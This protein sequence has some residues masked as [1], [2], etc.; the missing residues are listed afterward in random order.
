MRNTWWSVSGTA[1]NKIITNMLNNQRIWN[2]MPLFWCPSNEWLCT[3]PGDRDYLNQV[4]WRSYTSKTVG[5]NHIDYGK[6]KIHTASSS[7]QNYNDADHTELP[8]AWQTSSF[9]AITQPLD[10]VIQ[11]ILNDCKNI[12]NKDKVLI[13]IYKKVLMMRAGKW[14]PHEQKTQEQICIRQT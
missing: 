8:A 1:K 9:H 6:Y 12:C 10:R 7:A 4:C 5:F 11:Q 13:C 2:H 3:R 14:M